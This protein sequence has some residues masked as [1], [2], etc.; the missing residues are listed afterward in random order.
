MSYVQIEQAFKKFSDTVVLEHVSLE[1]QNGELVTLL[2]PSGCGKSTLLRCIAGLETLDSGTIK[3]NGKEISHLPPQQRNVGM[4]FQSYALFPNMTVFNNIAFGLKINKMDKKEIEKK[5]NQII[6]LVHLSGK[7]LSYPHELSGGQ[8]QRV[9][10]ARAI[11]SEPKIL[12]LD[13][14]LSA[15]DAKIRKNLQVELSQIQKKLNI[16]MIFVTHDQEE[17]MTI[18]DRIFVMDQGKIVQSGKPEEIYVS[19]NSKFVASFIGS[20]NVLT[21][22]DINQL[23]DETLQMGS[24]AIRP[25]VIE[26]FEDN[27]PSIS[28]RPGFGV[29]GSVVNMTVRGNVRRYEIKSQDVLLYVDELNVPHKPIFPEGLHIQAWIPQQECIFL[30]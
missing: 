7:E 12:L 5:V 26:L 25:E 15:L 23:S 2:G 22:T 14:P 28:K 21:H 3:V 20:Y 24:Y 9:A 18:S 10:L 6:D 4:V 27:M 11:V 30:G 16:T 13:E 29:K 17:A 19:P 8:Q 1:V